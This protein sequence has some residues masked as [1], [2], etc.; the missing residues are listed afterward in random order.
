MAVVSYQQQFDPAVGAGG[1]TSMVII[2]P[3]M[4]NGDTGQPAVFPEWADVSHQ[5]V[6]TFGAGGNVAIEGSNDGVNYGT[7]NDPFAVPLNYT[8]ASL[9]PRQAVEHA[10]NIRPH[11]TAGDGT[12]SLSVFSLFRRQPR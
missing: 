7:L 8:G 6:G 10:Q 5:V 12:T 4:Q 3:L 11:V 9:A 1:P 2:W